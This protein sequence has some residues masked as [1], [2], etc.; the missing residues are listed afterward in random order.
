MTFHRAFIS[1]ALL[2]IHPSVEIYWDSSRIH[3]SCDS[4]PIL[5][6]LLPHL[7]LL[8]LPSI[9]FLFWFICRFCFSFHSYF[10]FCGRIGIDSGFPSPLSDC[11]SPPPPHPLPRLLWDSLGAGL[12]FFA[13]FFCDYENPERSCAILYDPERFGTILIEEVSDNSLFYLPSF[14]IVKILSDPVRS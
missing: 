6:I 4:L 10:S 2:I 8:L 9:L 11:R 13:I 7:L 14:V 12:A 5:P 1:R 3:N